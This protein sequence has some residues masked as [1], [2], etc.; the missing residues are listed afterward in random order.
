MLRTNLPPWEWLW[1]SFFFFFTWS[2]LLFD[3][4][5]NMRHLCC[6]AS[7]CNLCRQDGTA[8]LSIFSSILRWFY[9]SISFGNSLKAKRYNSIASFPAS[10]CFNFT[11]VC[12]WIFTSS[13]WFRKNDYFHK[14][15]FRFCFLLSFIYIY[16]LSFQSSLNGMFIKC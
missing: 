15:I 5:F 2:F 3:C 10:L 6:S 8:Q 14:E 13:W 1:H 4:N 16:M 7:F 9:C 11:V 12:A